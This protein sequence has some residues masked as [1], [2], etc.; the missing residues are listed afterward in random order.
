MSLSSTSTSLKKGKRLA[1][2]LLC[3]SN[4][5]TDRFAYV[6]EDRF[7]K[8]AEY[9]FIENVFSVPQLVVLVKVVNNKNP[10][11][12]LF[13][14]QCYWFASLLVEVIRGY[15]PANTV[16][17]NP[18]AHHEQRGRLWTDVVPLPNLTRYVPKEKDDYIQKFKDA[19]AECAADT[20]R[21]RDEERQLREQV[22]LTL[23]L[24]R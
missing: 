21:I 12:E 13:S 3:F 19:W 2:D 20:Q 4:D 8:V 9:N 15:C 5:G 18:L 6:R 7:K 16:E 24:D 11:Y 1:G 10:D 23:S 17:E 22:S 14:H